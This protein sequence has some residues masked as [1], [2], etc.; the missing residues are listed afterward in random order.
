MKTEQDKTLEAPKIAFQMDIDGKGHHLKASQ[1]SSNELGKRLLAL[2]AME[3]D[4]HPQK[5]EEVYD[6]RVITVYRNNIFPIETKLRASLRLLFME[7]GRSWQE[8]TYYCMFQTGAL[9][10]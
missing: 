4:V 2:L 10:T 8:P 7:R 5:F 3:E 9:T 6:A 1:K